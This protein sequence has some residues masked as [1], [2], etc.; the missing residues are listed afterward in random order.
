MAL[1]AC[2]RCRCIQDGK[3]KPHP[4]PAMLSFDESGEPFL[5]GDPTEEQWEAH[6]E[7]VAESCE[8][9]GYL[10]AEALGNITKISRLREFLEHLQGT[11]GPRFPLLLES[12]VYN[13]T[14]T[15]D[16]VSANQS[17]QLLKEVN[18][19]LQSSDI[20]TAS[21]REFFQTIKRLCE[22]SIE[23]GNPIMF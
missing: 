22:A 2:V 13:G 21:E 14:H 3:A 9:G 8:H 6:D 7:W 16:W 15:G 18:V 4:F 5:E 23:T 17:V 11:P 19:V 20:L 1:D 10:V 12:V